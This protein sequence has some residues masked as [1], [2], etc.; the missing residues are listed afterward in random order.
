MATVAL[1][2]VKLG[3]K[4]SEDVL[5]P[6]GGV[7]FQKGR[8]VTPREL[9]I[10]QAFLVPKVQIEQPA[11]QADSAQE[12]AKQEKATAPVQSSTPLHDEY[13]QMLVLLR[14]VINEIRSGLSIPVMDIRN[15]L[16]KM[17]Q[18]E[19]S[20]QVLTF[21]PRQ[22]AERDYLLHNSVLVALTSY[23]IAQ[24]CGLPRKDWMPVALAGLLHDI[25]NVKIDPAILS[26]PT[27]LT[28]DENEEMKRHTVLGYQLLKNV[29]SL[30]EGVKLAALQHHERIDGSGYPLA[31]DTSKIH[32]Y[33]K[34]VAIADIYHAMT[35]NRFYRKAA[36]PYF[37]LE[38]IQSD[39]F[40]KLEPVYVRMFV[41]KVTQFHNGNI[42]KLSDDRVGEI[43]FTDAVH[44]TRPWVSVGG[45]IINLTID[46][47][48]HIKEVMG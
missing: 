6:L 35:L 1:S 39:A 16:E 28:A 14:R 3:D 9:D 23:R 7:L 29:A 5:T 15:Q 45:S 18:Y 24:W 36:S 25:G 8:I 40:G 2:Q 42:V 22:F 37:V 30:N 38:Q 43:V 19:N 31:I 27:A 48:L 46:R 34:I 41:E 13:D 33:A 47:H 11:N 44:P 17:M 21:M 26:K 12:N 4:I 10:M 20:Y 32:P